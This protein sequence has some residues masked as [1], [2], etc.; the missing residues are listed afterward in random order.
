[1]HKKGWVSQETRLQETLPAKKIY[2]I[3]PAGR[4]E[5]RGWLLT[6]VEV[7][8]FRHN[9]LIQLAWSSELTGDELDALL[10]R[11][12]EEISLQYQMRVAQQQRQP[13]RPDRT[14]REKLIWDHIE[15]NMLAA[16]RNE[17]EWVRQLQQDLKGQGF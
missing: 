5:L 14:A 7:P 6:H 17:L 15:E 11:Y 13:A 8:E 10:A 4:A 2:T 1:M 3:T 12:A 9:F 16:Y